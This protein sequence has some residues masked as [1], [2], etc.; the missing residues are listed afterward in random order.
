M[1]DAPQGSVLG[2]VLF[3]IFIELDKE[4]ECTLSEFANDIKLGGSTDLPR[5]RK[6]LQGW[7]AALRSVG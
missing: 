4:T 2:P 1:S 7:I 5:C 6:A 3:S